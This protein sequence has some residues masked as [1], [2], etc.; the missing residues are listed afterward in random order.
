MKI[1]F[2]CENYY[3]HFG[4]AEVLFKSLAEGFSKKGHQVSVLTH[5]LKG[6]EKKKS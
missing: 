6:T 1:L 5:R 3:P 2:V 4:G